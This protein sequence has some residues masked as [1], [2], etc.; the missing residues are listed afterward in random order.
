VY[1]SLRKYEVHE[2]RY[3]T[4]YSIVHYLHKTLSTGGDN[5]LLLSK[6]YWLNET[7]IDIYFSVR[8]FPKHLVEIQHRSANNLFRGKVVFVYLHKQISNHCSHSQQS[9]HLWHFPISKSDPTAHVIQYNH[10]KEEHKGDGYNKKQIKD[11]CMYWIWIRFLTV[12]LFKN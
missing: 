3:R 1:D 10:W 12:A 9:L 2:I 5:V 6:Y 4:D 11:N 7:I 8:I